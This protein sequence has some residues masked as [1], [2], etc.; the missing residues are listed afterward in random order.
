MTAITPNTPRTATTPP[1]PRLDQLLAGLGARAEALG[2]HALRYG[3]V[4]VL[5]WIGWS[6]LILGYQAMAPDRF[7]L[8]R[9]D[10]ATGWTPQE[11]R[12]D[13]HQGQPYLLQFVLPNF[14]FHTTAAY[15]ILR[16]NGVELSKRDFIGRVPGMTT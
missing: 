6:A 3:L 8:Q 11:T 9:P 15:A 16:H 14:F 13:S 5:L 2:G 12:A 10:R 7:E 1:G 4:L